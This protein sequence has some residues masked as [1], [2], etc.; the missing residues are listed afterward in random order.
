MTRPFPHLGG[1]YDVPD[2][3]K[4]KR[5][6]LF[7]IVALIWPLSTTLKTL[8]LSWCYHSKLSQILF[9]DLEVQIVPDK[10]KN[11][12][13]VIKDGKD[14]IFPSQDQARRPG[15]IH[16]T[17]RTRRPRCDIFYKYCHVST[18]I[19]Y[20]QVCHM[21]WTKMPPCEYLC[22]RSKAKA[23][24]RQPERK[25]E[26][27]KQVQEQRDNRSGWWPPATI[28]AN[29]T[30]RQNSQQL[31]VKMSLTCFSSRRSSNED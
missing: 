8:T 21:Q 13:D 5:S 12:I 18:N 30:R 19:V 22:G 6:S 23:R 10:K 20:F 26:R 2:E 24:D 29:R 14:T 7:V 1:Y 9:G 17:S 27:K 11:V 3:E 25:A 28:R 31:T 4:K 15:V 16:L